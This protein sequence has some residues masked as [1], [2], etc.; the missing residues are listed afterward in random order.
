MMR[1]I[2]GDHARFEQTYFKVHPGMYFTG[3]AEIC[4]MSRR[5]VDG[6]WAG[7][8][9]GMCKVQV[10]WGWGLGAKRRGRG[11]FRLTE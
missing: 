6:A 9:W 7:W 4:V 10:G 5:G 3:R 8:G 2:A 11:M 1:T